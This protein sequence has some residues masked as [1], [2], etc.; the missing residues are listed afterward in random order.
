MARPG[1]HSPQVQT[2]FGVAR[3]SVVMGPSDFWKFANLVFYPRVSIARWNA[4]DFMQA[5]ETCRRVD[6]RLYLCRSPPCQA[7]AR[8]SGLVDVLETERRMDCRVS[9]QP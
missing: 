6:A 1:P 7:V 9:D 8:C 4:G 5:A 3:G 2:G